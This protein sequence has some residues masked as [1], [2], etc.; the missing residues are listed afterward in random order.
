MIR[1]L[2]TRLLLSHPLFHF[3]PTTSTIMLDVIPITLFIPVGFSNLNAFI[4]S[5][6]AKMTLARN[7]KTQSLEHNEVSNQWKKVISF[8]ANLDT[9]DHGM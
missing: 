2:K 9:M 7:Q 3:E 8:V 6:I 5:L 4:T 1:H